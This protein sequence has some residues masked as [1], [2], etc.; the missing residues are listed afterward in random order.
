MVSTTSKTSQHAII[1]VW[2]PISSPSL[3]LTISITLQ[4]LHNST[5]VCFVLL[6][7]KAIKMK[8]KKKKQL[9]KCKKETSKQTKK[10]KTKEQK[11]KKRRSE[12]KRKREE[13]KKQKIW[14]L[15][16]FAYLIFYGNAF[17]VRIS[18]FR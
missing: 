16:A 14:R 2:M 4:F 12:R 10:K 11:N 5:L 13:D 3:S 7:C 8:K 1:F 17:S 9:I 18:R 15:G 6:F